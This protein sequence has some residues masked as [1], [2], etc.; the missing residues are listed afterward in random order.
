MTLAHF[1][2]RLQCKVFETSEVVSPGGFTLAQAQELAY[3]RLLIY[4]HGTAAGTEKFRLKVYADADLT[5]LIAT[6]AWSEFAN[7]DAAAILA[8]SAW[9]GYLRFDFAREWLPASQAFYLALESSGYTRN[10]NTFYVG[11]ILD[12]PV[13]TYTQTYSPRFAFAMEIYGYRK[14]AYP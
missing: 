11:G 10:L 13:P 8:A 5:K 7:P 14:V 3:I 6:S 4:K 12:W 2:N 9:L 1:S